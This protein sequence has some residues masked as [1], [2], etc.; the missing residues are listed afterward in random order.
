MICIETFRVFSWIT[1]GR[2][3]NRNNLRSCQQ[4]LHHPPN[5]CNTRR[6]SKTYQ[7]IQNSNFDPTNPPIFLESLHFK[8][9]LIP[10][11]RKGLL[12]ADEVIISKTQ[13]IQYYRARVNTQS[14]CNFAGYIADLSSTAA[15][16]GGAQ[17]DYRRKVFDN[18]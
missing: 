11:A 6:L 4:R 3:L 17:E 10:Y 2:R 12:V 1:K 9:S 15:P 18:L 13:G 14:A 5:E 16:V 7:L 8:P